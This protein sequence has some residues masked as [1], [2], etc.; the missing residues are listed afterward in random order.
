MDEDQVMT[1]LLNGSITLHYIKSHCSPYCFGADE[2][3]VDRL[4]RATGGGISNLKVPKDFE[5]AL[6]LAITDLRNAYT[7][8]FT[9][10]NFGKPG[11]YHRIEVKLNPA[12]RLSSCRVLARTG[13]YF[14]S[15][16]RR[17]RDYG[18]R[19]EGT[20]VDFCEKAFFYDCIDEVVRAGS[21][22]PGIPFQV[23][24]SNGK[25]GDKRELTIDIQ[26]DPA[27]IRFVSGDVRHS[28]KL[29]IAAFAI[30]SDTGKTNELYCQGKQEFLRKDEYRKLLQTKVHR[31]IT[32]PLPDAGQ[33][34]KIIVYDFA[35][36]G[37][38]QKIVDLYK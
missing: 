33:S 14:G 12:G 13:Y 31:T 15:S 11:S 23:A 28:F 6:A 27:N 34:L 21:D 5:D 9:P 16:S 4:A 30:D 25:T 17:P 36:K 20:G 29:L 35:Q 38:G 19:A 26:I 18:F 8:G 22:I 1:E 2:N 32:V 24:A 7:L 3:V 10:A 37:G